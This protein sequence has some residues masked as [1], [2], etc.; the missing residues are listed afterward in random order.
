MVTFQENLQGVSNSADGAG[1]SFASIIGHGLMLS[2]YVGARVELRFAR[3]RE[4]RRQWL[5]V[6]VTVR[7]EA[8][9]AYT[10]H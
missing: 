8:T 10:L 7:R 5:Q 9:A 1:Q 3:H 4:P 2:I 6:V